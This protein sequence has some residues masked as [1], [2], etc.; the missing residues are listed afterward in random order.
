[1]SLVGLNYTNIATETNQSEQET[2]TQLS[3][4]FEEWSSNSAVMEK[5]RGCFTG[6]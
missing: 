5:L 2:A 3:G 1:L 4:V 6:A